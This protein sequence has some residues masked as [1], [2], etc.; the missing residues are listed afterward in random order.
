MNSAFRLQ[1]DP[2]SMVFIAFGGILSQIYRILTAFRP[3]KDPQS[4]VFIAFG[5]ILSQVYRIL[6]AFRLQKDT[7][8]M[9]FIAFWWFE[10]PKRFQ[11]DSQIA[12]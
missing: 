5:C 2:Q 10:V 4:M 6:T 11:I 8:S 1:K 12:F 3:Q 7:Q 9:V